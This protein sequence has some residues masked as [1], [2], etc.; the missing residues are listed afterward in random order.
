VPGRPTRRSLTTVA[1]DGQL[2]TAAIVR[3][4]D[5]AGATVE[6]VRAGARGK[7]SINAVLP[8]PQ[9]VQGSPTPTPCSIRRASASWWA[10][11]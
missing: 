5:A 3:L 4:R 1:V 2:I 10:P 9:D 11:C 8:T 7:P 6:L